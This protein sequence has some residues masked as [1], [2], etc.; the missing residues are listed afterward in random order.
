M[1]FH[2]FLNLVVVLAML[3]V[4]L[5]PAAA[6]ADDVTVTLAIDS[7][8]ARDL[9]EDAAFWHDRQD[10]IIFVYSLQEIDERGRRIES[11]QRNVTWTGE[12]KLFTRFIAV[13][14]PP[15]TLTIAPT[16]SVEVSLYMAETEGSLDSVLGLV[17]GGCT[18][19]AAPLIK[20][21]N[22]YA[23][24]AGIGCVLV[25]FFSAADYQ[26]VSDE[27]TRTFS[28]R[29]LSNSVEAS[30]TFESHTNIVGAYI[31]DVVYEV[32][33]TLETDQPAS[34]PPPTRAPSTSSSGSGSGSA[35][36]LMV[37]LPGSFG[38]EIGCGSATTDL[39]GDWEPACPRMSDPDGNGLYTYET[40][41]IPAGDW[42][43][44]VT[45]GG[46]WDDN[47]GLDAEPFGP[48]IPFTVE[49]DGSTVLFTYNSRT[50]ALSIVVN[51]PSQGD[52]IRTVT[53]RD[54]VAI[55]G[56]FGSEIGCRADEFELDGDWEPACPAM[57]DPDGNGLYTF[58]TRAIPAGEWEVKVTIGGT[59]DNNYGLN[60]EAAG[61]NIP[62]R[63]AEDGTRVL[64]TYNSRTHALSITQSR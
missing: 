22:P 25:Q 41:D 5:I 37:S 46:T 44:K 28:P 42:E 36:A 3:G 20:T 32:T 62:F 30:T 27:P 58:E 9:Q 23:V 11:N 63:V 53:T 39:G 38:S 8:F 31:N 56:S 29:Q 54:G 26:L 2:H 51:E 64:F 21:A 52:S 34:A 14:F 18:A 40:S 60:G 24:A 7:I 47:Y 57:S 16:S 61:P 13:Q 43:V 55:P 35:S 4:G 45:I 6:Q 15:I 10:E 1:R 19:A 48:N 12:F 59:W 33:Y 49:D 50:H 17:Q